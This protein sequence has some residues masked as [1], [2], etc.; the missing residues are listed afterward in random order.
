MGY[1]VPGVARFRCN[2][3]LQRGTMAAV[4]RRVP[5]EIQGIE[6]LNL[7]DVI[8]SFTELPQWTGAGHRSD[9]IR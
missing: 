7:P 3:F 8:S 5:F 6:D 1:G 4:F 2:I 9:R